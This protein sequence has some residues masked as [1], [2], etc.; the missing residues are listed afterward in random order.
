VTLASAANT[1]KLCRH[2]GKEYANRPRVM[3]WGCYAT[4]GVRDMYPGRRDNASTPYDP[5]PFAAELERV[6]CARS[7]E[8]AA[9]F[10]DLDMPGG[11]WE[12]LL[13]LL[14]SAQRLQRAGKL[15]R[16]SNLLAN[17]ADRE[18]STKEMECLRL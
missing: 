15:E 1:R 10:A 9:V 2:C 5:A 6:R 3:C 8:A 4:R 12:E 16:A 7:A 14:A 17:L 11:D 13:R 18:A